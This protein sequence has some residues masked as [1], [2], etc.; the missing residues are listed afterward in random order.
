[1]CFYV[2]ESPKVPIYRLGAGAA[3]MSCLFFSVGVLL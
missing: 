2:F 1:M 3:G